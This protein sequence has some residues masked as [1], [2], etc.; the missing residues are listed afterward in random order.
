M[1][2]CINVH[3]IEVPREHVETEYYR[4]RNCHVRWDVPK[5]FL[6]APT[7]AAQAW[8]AAKIN[9]AWE[10]AEHAELV[11]VNPLVDE[12]CSVEDLA[13]TEA[14]QEEI[15]RVEARCNNEGVWDYH[16]EYFDP[17]EGWTFADQCGGF[18]GDDW[19]D[20]GYDVDMKEAALAALEQVDTKL[21][22]GW[23]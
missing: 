20:S 4:L 13:G 8:R 23:C 1:K 6:P 18:I 21:C 15:N 17:V 7:P 22:Q 3:G 9:M 11:R 12:C 10:A 2:Q 5:S 14:T 16:T 19:I